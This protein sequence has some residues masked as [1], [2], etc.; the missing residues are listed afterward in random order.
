MDKSE[1]AHD[2]LTLAGK[3]IP[4]VLGRLPQ[5]DLRFYAENPRVYSIIRP[6]EAEPL[7]SEIEERLGA[8]DHVKQLR[9]SIIANRGLIDPLIVR[10]GD[11]VVL[12]GNS[13]LAAYRILAKGDPIRWGMVKVKLLP[14]DIGED[15]VLSLLGEYH[16][17][18]RKDWA[19]YEQA[20]YLYRRH[21]RHG[22]DSAKM[23]KEMGLST[24][25]VNH[26]LSVYGFMV[27][28]KDN[29][30]DKWSYY[31]EYLKHNEIK[32]VREEHPELDGVVAAKIAS[33][34]IPRAVDVREKVTAIVRARGKVLKKFMEKEGTLEECYEGAIVHGAKNPWPK[35]FKDFKMHLVDPD[36]VAALREM[37]EDHRKRCLYELRKINN[38]IQRL[39]KKIE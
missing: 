36:T 37:T 7:Q 1:W 32:K 2:T 33:G 6:D 31:D 23:A 17:S 8:M 22:V 18:G 28:H 12:E 26:L 4:V 29:N 5:S 27:E 3:E 30:V 14:S 20:G 16:I 10:D 9:Q 21:S 35:R 25:M 24:R 11:Y 15:M 38:A 19:P 34:E 13:R 39:L